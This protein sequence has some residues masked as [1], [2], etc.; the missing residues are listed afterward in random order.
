MD[1]AS[2]PLTNPARLALD[3]YCLG[4][5][6]DPS[7]RLEEHA[8]GV[9]RTRAGLGSGL[10][11][12]L[13]GPR[14]RHWVNV[15]VTE[16]FAQ[17][18]PWTLRLAGLS[19]DGPLYRLVDARSGAVYP[20][21][22]PPEPAWYGKSTSAGTPMTHV[23]LLQGTYLG[24]Y[25]GGI[26]GFWAGR[27]QDACGFCTSG[28]NVG[29]EERLEKTVD[30]V[31]ET[32]L[33]AKRESGVT[34][35]HLNM[36][37]AGPETVRGVE[38]YVKALKERVGVLVGVQ[39][40]PARDLALYDRLKALGVDH[41]S[42]CYEFHDAE[43]LAK[44]CPGKSR[45]LG[46]EAYFRALEHCARLFGRGSCSGEIIAGVEPI[47]TTLRAIDW[48][49]S[50]GA[51]PTVCVFRPL[52]GA[53]MHDVPPPDPDALVPVFR[54]VWDACRRHLVPVGLAP[55]IEVSIVLTPDDTADLHE[56]PTTTDRMWRAAL[57]VARLASRP[58]FAARMRPAAPREG[59]PE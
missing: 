11:L 22:L 49:A 27:G 14:K 26:C 7:C 40:T 58:R 41:L 47:E 31:V 23:G 55:N 36:G 8:R 16:P 28:V 51:F 33:A 15:P 45:A 13:P 4:A 3:L 48:I 54:A 21:E 52:E 12:C 6:I 29:T 24:V 17:R 56:D 25:V 1:P 34:F 38:P 43:V 57:A 39:A 44:W 2:P 37:Y 19:S 18:S 10:E 5:R 59:D 9:S 30:D 35:V 42:F 32:A 20:V 50:V 53:R 46:Q